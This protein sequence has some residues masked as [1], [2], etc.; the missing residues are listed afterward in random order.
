MEAGRLQREMREQL[1][2][3]PATMACWLKQHGTAVYS[4]MR[5]QLFTPAQK[6]RI[7][8]SA[9]CSTAA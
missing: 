4:R 5:R 6:H 1:G 7:G 3:N 2:T 9:S 8:L